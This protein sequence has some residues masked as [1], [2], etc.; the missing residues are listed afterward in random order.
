MLLI[1]NRDAATRNKGATRAAILVGALAVIGLA[2]VTA[3][4]WRH[5][6]P[7]HETSTAVNSEATSGVAGEPCTGAPPQPVKHIVVIVLENHDY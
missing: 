1:V 4:A 5:F 2:V 3:S 7:D 6:R